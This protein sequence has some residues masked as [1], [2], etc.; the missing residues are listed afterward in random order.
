MG[1]D[2]DPHPNLS[3]S[4]RRDQGLRAHSHGHSNCDIVAEL[5]DHLGLHLISAS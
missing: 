1:K 3:I 4:L 2:A 5:V